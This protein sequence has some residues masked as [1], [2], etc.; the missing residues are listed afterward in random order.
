MVITYQGNN[1]FKLQSG[2]NSLLIDPM[3]KRSFKG[4]NVVL[5]T[6]KPRV[7]EQ[8]EGED[9]NTFIID[10]PGEYEIQGIHI[11]GWNMGA[12]EGKLLT[13][14][15]IICDDIII[16]T[17]GFI[18]KELSPELVGEIGATD[19]LIIPGG[20]KPYISQSAAAKL[21]RQIEP[22]VIIP[23]LYKDVRP[24]LKELG[25]EKKTAEEKLVIKKKDL[26]PHALTVTWLKA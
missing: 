2:T 25:A 3:D 26:V 16:T 9:N 24:F 13:C 22:S 15:R 17:L 21:A 18:P 10:H 12:E 6:T 4:T 19:I 7:A 14:Y 8:E 11:R 20:G 5:F 23:S 1:Y